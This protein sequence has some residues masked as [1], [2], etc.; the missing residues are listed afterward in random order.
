MHDIQLHMFYARE[1]EAHQWTVHDHNAHINVE[2]QAAPGLTHGI[3]MDK[4][5]RDGT[6]SERDIT[7]T[8]RYLVCPWGP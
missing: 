5:A 7:F 2:P 6:E 8:W 1:C 4:H 3:L